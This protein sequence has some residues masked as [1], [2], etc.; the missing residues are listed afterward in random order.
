MLYR[1]FQYQQAAEQL[2]LAVNGGQTE[3]GFPI[4][5]LPLVNDLRVAEYYFTYGLALAR[6]NQCGKAL[7]ITQDIQTNIHFDEDTMG[8][9]NENV[10]DIIT[11]CQENLANPAV[12]TPIVTSA[13]GTVVAETSTPEPATATPEPVETSTP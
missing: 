4:K 10:N 12:D 13:D 5:N 9:I 6:T 1:N 8:L 7:Q 3:D 11:T 2:S